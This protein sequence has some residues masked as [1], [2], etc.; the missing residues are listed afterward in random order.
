M[1]VVLHS[2]YFNVGIESK[3]VRL[4]LGQ[5][6]YWHVGNRCALALIFVCYFGQGCRHHS[7]SRFRIKKSLKFLIVFGNTWCQND[8]APERFLPVSSG[9]VPWITII[10]SLQSLVNYT[11]V[12]NDFDMWINPS[13][14][15]SYLIHHDQTRFYIFLKL[16]MSNIYLS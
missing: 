7:S 14:N 5:Q 16:S 11:N 12:R 15:T 10:A 4:S 6:Q 2:L 9:R 3:F 1:L 8:S 13:L